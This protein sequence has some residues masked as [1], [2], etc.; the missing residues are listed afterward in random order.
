MA[1]DRPAFAQRLAQLMRHHGISFRVLAARTYYGKS[2]LHELATGRKAPTVEVAAALDR[3]FELDRELVTLVQ[4]PHDDALELDHRVRASDVSRTTLTALEDAFEALAVAYPTTQPRDLIPRVR[5]HLGQVAGLLDARQTLAQ[6]R[7][8]IVLGGW[9]SLLGATLHID[10]QEDPA[11]RQRL[12]TARRL[13]RDGEHPEIEAWCLETRAW[14]V[15]TEGDYRAAVKL[16]RQ[17]QGVAP[18]GSSALIQA[19]AQEGRA[20]ARMGDLAATRRVLGRV[21]GMVSNL[22]VPDRPEHHYRY[23]PDKAIA[24]TA[25]TLAW[26]GDPSAV[27]YARAVIDRLE[28][29]GIARP[30]RVASARLDLSLAL[31][32]T[33]QADE[34]AHMAL[35]AVVSGRVVASNWWR[36]TEV[37]QQVEAL[38]VREAVDLRDACAEYEPS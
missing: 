21:A 7:Q 16:S 23:D 19:T 15:L 26:A 11:A 36:V 27:E 8:L 28:S 18:A 37:V 2:Y 22:E 30:R 12:T 38:G 4:D 1:P 5:H 13:A 24:Y 14:A 3:A 20:Y 31:L 34:A 35:Q 17:A 9:F 25:T 6:H 29:N 32:A 10:L 33:K